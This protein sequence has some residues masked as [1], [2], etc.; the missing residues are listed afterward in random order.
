MKKNDIILIAAFVL[1]AFLCMAG[2]RLFGMKTG[3][4]A[5]V[6]IDGKLFKTLKLSEDTRLEIDGADGGKNILVIKDGKA[7]MEDA[8]CADKICVHQGAISHTNENIVCLPHKVVVLIRGEQES[9]DAL[10]Q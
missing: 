5:D 2:I 1:I 10:V 9:I 7:F 8:D 4:T 3:K 6:T